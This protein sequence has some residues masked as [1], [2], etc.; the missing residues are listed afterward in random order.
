MKDRKK[1]IMLMAVF[2]IAALV[3]CGCT[4]ESMFSESAPAPLQTPAVTLTPKPSE[5]NPKETT[6]TPAAEVN[7]AET[8]PALPETEDNDEAVRVSDVDE[9]LR[10]SSLRTASMIFGWQQITTKHMI[11]APIPGKRALTAGS[12]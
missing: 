8:E 12:W 1:I 10:R 3:L 5:E 9:F 11:T 4:Q 6:P 7:S 2:L